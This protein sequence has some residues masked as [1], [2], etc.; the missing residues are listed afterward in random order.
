MPCHQE[1]LSEPESRVA[2]STRR[3]YYGVA[4]RYG[5]DILPSPF[6]TST[7]MAGR[8]SK[9]MIENEFRRIALAQ[10]LLPAV[11]TGTLSSDGSRLPDDLP[12]LNR[13]TGDPA[14][15]PAIVE[16]QP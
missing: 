2:G 5:S 1:G 8:R 11:P 12:G 3:S 9:D 14:D 15:N 6:S 16:Q 7:D 13:G 10:G 4:S